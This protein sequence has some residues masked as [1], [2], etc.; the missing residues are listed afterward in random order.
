LTCFLQDGVNVAPIEYVRSGKL[1]ALAVTTATRS[2]ALPGTSTIAEFVPGYEASGWCGF[3]SPKSTPREIID[4]LNSEINTALA[5]LKIMAQR[6]QVHRHQS[7]L[8]RGRRGHSINLSANRMEPG[9]RNQVESAVTTLFS[10]R[11][12]QT[13][14]RLARACIERIAASTQAD[15]FDAGAKAL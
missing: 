15:R 7:G 3:G 13:D 5:D 9:E 10:S 4:K 14:I 8:T 1:R 6:D 11:S 12:D 2:D